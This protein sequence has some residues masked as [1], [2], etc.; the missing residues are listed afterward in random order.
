MK[1]K[2]TFGPT[3]SYNRWIIHEIAKEYDCTS[4]SHGVEPD[5]YTVVSFIITKKLYELLIGISSL[6]V[7]Y[8]K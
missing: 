2:Y 5:R 7:T 6:Q 1:P 4:K 3:T 8:R